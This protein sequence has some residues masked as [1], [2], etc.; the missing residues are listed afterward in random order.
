VAHVSFNTPIPYNTNRLLV[1]SLLAALAFA[2]ETANFDAVNY[3]DT[4][5]SFVW[6][7][8]DYLEE[9]YSTYTSLGLSIA[10]PCGGTKYLVAVK[11]GSGATLASTAPRIARYDGGRAVL[12]VQ[13]ITIFCPAAQRNLRAAAFH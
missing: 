8:L 4:S 11:S 2:I 12:C 9:A 5:D 1:L 3:A 7:A 6:A 13:N 10:P